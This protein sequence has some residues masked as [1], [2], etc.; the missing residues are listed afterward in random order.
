MRLLLAA[1]GIVTAAATAGAC[2]RAAPA[3]VAPTTRPPV[4]ATSKAAPNGDPPSVERA[5]RR[6]SLASARDETLPFDVR[7]VPGRRSALLVSSDLLNDHSY[8]RRIDDRG[9]G[10]VRSLV[11]RHVVGAL[12]GDRPL[13]VSARVTGPE[14]PELCVERLNET[15]MRCHR[16]QA[17]A[18]VLLAGKPVLVEERK[19]RR[20]RHQP[21]K[22]TKK[23]KKTKRK[24]TKATKATNVRIW[25]HPVQDDGSL[26]EA[27]DTELEFARPSLPEMGM[28]DAVGTNFGARLLWYEHRPPRRVARRKI[29]R[30]A[31]RSGRLDADG[32]LVQDSS[33]TLFKGDRAYGFVQGHRRPRLFTTGRIA[34][35]VGRFVDEDKKTSGFEAKRLAPLADLKGPKSVFGVDPL[36]LVAP[37]SLD[38]KRLSAMQTLW[39]QAP[40]L[41]VGQSSREAARVAWV[42]SRGWFL[43]DG[44]LA[45]ASREDG[46]VQAAP[47][48]FVAKRARLHWAAMNHD[49]QGVALTDDG[50]IRIAADG[51]IDQHPTHHDASS[52]QPLASP[53][54]IG[55]SWWMLKPHTNASGAMVT[56]VLPSTVDVVGLAAYP[57]SSALVGGEQQ[58]MFIAW[59]SGRL[60]AW[61][62]AADGQYVKLASHR[63]PVDLG[64]VA[65]PRKAGGALIAGIAADGERRIVMAALT[66]EGQLLPSHASAIVPERVNPKPIEIRARP[67]GGAWLSSPNHVAWHDDDGRPLA[68]VPWPTENTDAACIDGEPS[69]HHWPAAAPGVMQRLPAPTGSCMST[70]PVTLASGERRWLGTRVDGID[71]HAEL[72]VVPVRPQWSPADSATTAAS[73]ATTAL[74]NATGSATT[75]EP[76][77]AAPADLDSTGRSPCP[78]D[79]VSVGRF[80]IDRFEGQLVDAT[81]GVALSPDYPTT[82]RLVQ[83]TLDAWVSQRWYY[84]DLHAHA[85]PLPAL[86]RPRNAS[87]QVRVHSRRGVI[88]SGYVSGHVAKQACTAAGK[89]LCTRFEWLGACR[90]QQERKFPYG[91]DYSHGACNVFRYAH[92]AATLHDN[93]SIGHLDPRLN[94]VL[95]K[96][97]PML[98]RTGATPRCASQWG[99][100]AIY[101]MVGNLD[102][103]VETKSGGFAGGFYSRSTRRGCKSLITA[104]PRRYLDYSLGIRCCADAAVVP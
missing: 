40:R 15:T 42:G 92:P 62:L 101:D 87:P 82:P 95:D 14:G 36:A 6:T 23:T 3:P 2:V 79:M 64:F 17:D 9:I 8:L 104:H 55:D 59:R 39:E 4:G 1:V 26:G 75:P 77:A 52:Q 94:R 88:P 51:H 48:P 53:V 54:Q 73:R 98:R 70:A 16:M 60:E 76:R 67:D 100:D 38:A 10:P 91:D 81:S 63:S 85:M 44:A 29:Q 18:L 32:K 25:I 12:D 86:L 90:G 65:A 69:R 30:A 74:P 84:G 31:L 45:S 34:M 103:W 80:C 72:V 99:D 21:T 89:R 47:A 56:R 19:V 33:T 61:R 11:G 58:G 41:S 37:T 43:E 49:G 46:R 7:P 35:Y 68:D 13:L 57:D 102:E 97:K 50:I 5:F 22:Q 24:A 71:S 78:A 96:G 66:S 20:H 93:P 83:I 28:V 27:I